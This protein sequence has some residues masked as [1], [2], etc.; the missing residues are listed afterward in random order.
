MPSEAK[1]L[2]IKEIRREFDANPYAFIT[3]FDKMTVADS[4]EFRRS[5][6][7]VSSRSMVVKQTLAKKVFAEMDCGS[8]QNHLNGSVLITFGDKEPQ[9]I[10]K[11]IVEFSKKNNKFTVSGVVFEKQVYDQGFVKQLATLPSRHELLTQVVVRV[12]SPISGFVMTLAQVLRGFAVVIN[13]IK[14]QR[15][16]APATA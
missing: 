16:A 7:K 8:A 15:E 5:L 6:E 9:I 13:E 1:E 14:K 11:A 2:M 4:Y 12:K 10:S 3:S